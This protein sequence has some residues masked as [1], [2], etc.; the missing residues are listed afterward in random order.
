MSPSANADPNGS[1]SVA[2]GSKSTRGRGRFRA[3]LRCLSQVRKWPAR[4][5]SKRHL[6]DGFRQA[7]RIRSPAQPSF[8]A[9]LPPIRPLLRRSSIPFFLLGTQV[10]IK[11]SAAAPV[12][13][14]TLLCAAAIEMGDT[15]RGVVNSC[16]VGT[17]SRLYLGQST[18]N[19]TVTEA[20]WRAVGGGVRGGGGPG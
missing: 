18:P 1:S 3:I 6:T 13:L 8:S 15:P 11:Q 17:V 12:L 9:A 7:P 20:Q 4:V 2:S 14:M 16:S 10:R 19:G 5:P